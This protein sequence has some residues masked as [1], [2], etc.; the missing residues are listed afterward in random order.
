MKGEIGM[1]VIESI[2]KIFQKSKTRKIKCS[3]CGYEY[4]ERLKKCPNC[5]G[6]IPVLVRDRNFIEH[7]EE[8]EKKQE[9]DIEKEETKNTKNQ[10]EEQQKRLSLAEQMRRAH[11]IY[12]LQ[13]SQQQKSKDRNTIYRSDRE[14]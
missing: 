4:D 5:N 12:E 2:K 1:K 8:Q 3:K 13:N 7:V 6:E 14:R 10:Q 9:D 11:Q